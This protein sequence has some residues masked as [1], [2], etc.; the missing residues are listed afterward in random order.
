MSARTTFWIVLIVAMSAWVQSLKDRIADL[1]QQL[2]NTQLQHEQQ[3]REASDALALAHAEIR[4]LEHGHAQRLA[5]IDSRHQQEFADA[6]TAADRT[7]ADLRNGTVRLR[8]QLA[9]ASCPA[10]LQFAGPSP[11]VNEEA[12]GLRPEDAGFLVR[13]ADECDADLR[14]AQ[15]VIDEDRRL[16]GPQPQK[17]P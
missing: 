15:A 8:K 5:D 2:S 9:A 17:E 16:C 3:A 4:E 7:V 11:G 6:Q 13:L 1:Q 12:P 10:G 14:A